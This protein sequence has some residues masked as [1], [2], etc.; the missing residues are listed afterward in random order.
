[1]TYETKDSGARQEFD[2]G[3]KRD[4]EEGK[5]RFDL[6]IPDGVPYEDQ[7]LTR[8]ALLLSRGAVKYDARNWEQATGDEEIAR[9]RS[10]AFRHFMQWLS[11]ETDEDHAAAVMFNLLVVETTEHKRANP[12]RDDTDYE[13]AA[14]EILG[15][16]PVGVDWDSVTLEVEAEG[17]SLETIAIAIGLPVAE[18]ELM[19]ES[20]ERDR[21]TALGVFPVRFMA[22]IAR[23]PGLHVDSTGETD[24]DPE[25]D[26]SDCVEIVTRDLL[27][28]A[29]HHATEIPVEDLRM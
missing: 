2:S 3:M 28:R 22:G 26:G 5:A 10:S 24:E 17:V 12:P 20:A 14:D 15:N 7:L 16:R 1:M 27:N 9:A 4:S 11:G 18:V 21:M 23:E 29:W 19:A 13:A 8:L 25:P 6:I